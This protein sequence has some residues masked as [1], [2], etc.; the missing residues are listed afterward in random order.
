MSRVSSRPLILVV[1]VLLL[2]ATAF[3]FLGGPSTKTFTAHFD[4]AVSIYPGSD[5][6]VLGVTVGEVTAVI[7]EGDSVRVEMEYDDQYTLP[8][9][10]QAVIITP[11]LVADR[12]VQITPVW[13]EGDRA[14][15]DG[16][17]IALDRTASPVELDRIY[18]SLDELSTALGPN[19]ANQNGSLD[20]LLE[21]SAT[22]LD[23]Q[24]AR[25]NQMILD[26]SKAADTFGNASG[27]MFATVRNLDAFTTELARNDRTVQRFITQLTAAS[28]TLAGEREELSAAL[29]ALAGALVT[30]RTFV[31]DNRDQVTGE[32]ED[33]TAVLDVLVKEQDSLAT[34]LEKGPLGASNLALAFDSTTGSIGSRVQVGP[35]AEDLDG[36]LCAVVQNAQIPDADTACRLFKQ[37]YDPVGGALGGGTPTLPDLGVRLPVPDG[38]RNGSREPAT[39]MDQ[40]LGGGQ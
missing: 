33:L 6:R 4:R 21:A 11:T 20:T 32:V 37:I 39:S 9:D 25:A 17:E 16:A 15:A 13:R 26:M 35:N 8:A 14:L 22:T 27:E 3:A 24:G 18:A 28:G 1:V 30:V 31:R 12:F 2:A 34:A 23:G 7:P 36:F 5:V 38:E 19:G 10:A 40:L 29:E